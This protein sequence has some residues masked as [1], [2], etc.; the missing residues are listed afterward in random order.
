V[1]NSESFKREKEMSS[2]I[3]FLGDVDSISTG[4][5]GVTSAIIGNGHALEALK[6]LTGFAPPLMCNARAEMD[7]LTF[8]IKWDRFGRD[9]ECSICGN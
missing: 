2:I 3:E 8:N 4:S 9:P 5:L 7:F 1:H 6:V